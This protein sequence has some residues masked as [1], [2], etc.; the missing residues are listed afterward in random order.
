MQGLVSCKGIY[1]AKKRLVTNLDSFSD[2]HPIL[3][4]WGC[5]KH[6]K[7]MCPS[8]VIYFTLTH[9]LFVHNAITFRDKV[10]EKQTG[11]AFPYPSAPLY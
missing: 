4:P 3:T 9:G 2:I 10:R 5:S 8:S 1:Q 6:E 7:V 11:E